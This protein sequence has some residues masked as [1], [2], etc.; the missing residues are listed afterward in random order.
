MYLKLTKSANKHDDAS[1]SVI[2]GIDQFPGRK[3][4]TSLGMPASLR[5]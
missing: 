2:M 1:P 5:G 4:L 3:C